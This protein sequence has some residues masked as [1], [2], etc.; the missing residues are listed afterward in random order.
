MD[1]L[2]G[3]LAH[4][5]QLTTDG[6]TVHLRAV[7]EAF[8]AGIDYAMLVKLYGGSPESAKGRY[9]PAECIGCWRI[10]VKAIPTT[11]MSQHPM[12]SATTSQSAWDFAGSCG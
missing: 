3:R 10:P 6:H 1:D 4:K 9:S 7:D 12:L 11:P 8:G 2:S 5:V